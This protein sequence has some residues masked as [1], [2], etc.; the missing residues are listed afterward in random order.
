MNSHY[1]FPSSNEIQP[2]SPSELTP[3][4]VE[5]EEVFTKVHSSIK[6]NIEN[7]KNLLKSKM[8]IKP[9][10][11]N[12]SDESIY[13]KSVHDYETHLERYRALLPF[14]RQLMEGVSDI[15]QDNMNGI[16]EFYRKVIEDVSYG[17]DKETVKREINEFNRVIGVKYKE[18]VNNISNFI[19]QSEL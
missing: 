19:N 15:C 11:I 4:Y 2:L 10:H 1:K 13:L 5:I 18:A 12:F 6:E 3:I 16:E 8:P 9:M 14:I 7:I 17:V